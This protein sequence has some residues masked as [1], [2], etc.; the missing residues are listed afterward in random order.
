MARWML[1][2]SLVAALIMCAIQ[3]VA[4]QYSLYWRFWWFDIPP[5]LAGGA[6]LGGLAS[7]LVGSSRERFSWPSV[8][9]TAVLVLSFAFFGGSLWE[10]YEYSIGYTFN[11]I[12]NY[13]LDTL[14]DLLMDIIGA[15]AAFWCYRRWFDVLR[16]KRV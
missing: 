8:S 10:F 11:A 13:P 9:V 5:H 1:V 2:I 14:K 3:V 15:G 12:G 16:F 4:S 7:W 6:M